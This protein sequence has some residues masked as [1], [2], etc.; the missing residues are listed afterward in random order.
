MFI[1]WFSYIK[2][3]YIK[4]TKISDDLR[5]FFNC[6]IVKE[7]F[8]KHQSLNGTLVSPLDLWQGNARH[9]SAIMK[10]FFI[11]EDTNKTLHQRSWSTLENLF[12]CDI[13]FST[14]LFSFKWLRDL[15]ATGDIEGRQLARRTIEFWYNKKIYHK[16]TKIAGVHADVISAQRLSSWITLYNFFGE[17]SPNEFKKCFFKLLKN[18]YFFL[19]RKMRKKHDFLTKL[20]IIKALVEYNVYFKLD[21]VFLSLILNEI[22]K[23]IQC[24]QKTIIRDNP[25]ILDI[26]N[27]FCLL[28]ELRT[29]LLQFEKYFS[30]FRHKKKFNYVFENIQDSLKK[31]KGIIRFFRHSNGELC[32][33]SHCSNAGVLNEAVKSRDVDTALTHVDWLNFEDS[34]F[35]ENKNIIKYS[36]KQIVFFLDI[37]NSPPI[38]AKAEDFGSNIA[39]N[40]MNFE[41]SFE[42]SYIVTESSILLFQK[43]NL[44]KFLKNKDLSYYNTELLKN[45]KINHY[46]KEV[47]ADYFRFAGSVSDNISYIHKREFFL[48]SQENL[49]K[50]ID[51]VT[52]GVTSQDVLLVLKFHLGSMLKLY[53]TDQLANS[54]SVQ[55]YIESQ[56]FSNRNRKKNLKQKKIC[57][58]KV[59]S[60][61]KIFI[62]VN[63]KNIMTV[64]CTLKPQEKSAINWSFQI[65]KSSF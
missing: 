50:C 41:F 15:K 20:I 1:G 10:G 65:T 24:F 7:I 62:D 52:T 46:S 58:F 26:F 18:E 43:N 11:V 27:T 60:A 6:S 2:K 16:Q 30:N 44:P 22:P 38:K 33:L 35:F 54:G 59:D 56:Q 4:C 34:T 42:Q 17:S 40:T 48:S 13:F 37:S 47:G 55:F 53:N 28:I 8:I 45:K 51:S 3:I 21:G 31:I 49:L 36:K 29:A 23:L 14:Y 19:K 32:S 61:G 57:I 12:D 39:L 64:F 9:G 63:K 5:F 25:K